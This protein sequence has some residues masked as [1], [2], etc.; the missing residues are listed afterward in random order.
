MEVKKSQIFNMCIVLVVSYGAQSWAMT[1]KEE[2]KI[3]VFQNS[4]E[5]S[6]LKYKRKDRKRISEIK[7]KLKNNINILE[8]IKRKQWN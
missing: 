7:S 1:K 4:I 5:R 6:I 2:N 3:T 8:E